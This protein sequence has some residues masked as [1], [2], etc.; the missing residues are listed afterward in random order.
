MLF[1]N[2]GVEISSSKR[3]KRV[4]EKYFFDPNLTRNG[5][6]LAQQ[7]FWG[8][9]L[10]LSP[11][12]WQRSHYLFFVNETEQEIEFHLTKFIRIMGNEYFKTFVMQE[13]PIIKDD[14]T[15]ELEEGEI[16]EDITEEEE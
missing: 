12:L 1:T 6:I 16:L 10:F 8:F 11:K 5:N 13:K 2:D 9:V 7:L 3:A 4:R 15:E 14:S